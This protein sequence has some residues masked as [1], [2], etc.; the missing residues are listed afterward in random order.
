MSGVKTFVH[1]S[2]EGAY[3]LHARRKELLNVATS[4]PRFDP[5]DVRGLR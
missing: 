3:V 5:N 1:Q 4:V 2:H